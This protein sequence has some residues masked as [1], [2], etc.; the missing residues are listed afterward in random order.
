MNESKEEC[1]REFVDPLRR[2][3]LSPALLARIFH[4]AALVHFNAVAEHLSMREASRRLNVASSAVSRQITQLEDALGMALFARDG[5]RLA[6]SPAGEILFRHTRRLS[7]VLEAAVG[8]LEM[9]RGLKTG[10]VRVA[11]AESVGIAFLPRVIAEFGTRYPRLHIEVSVTSSTEVIR[12][13]V[14]D[15][16]EIGFGFV[17]APHRQIDVALR[18]DVRIGVAMRPDHPLSTISGPLTLTDCLRHPIAVATPEISIRK[19]IEPFLQQ[20]GQALPPLVE[21]DSIR[22]LVELAL[23]GRYL[24][25]MTPIGAQNEIATGA[26]I[27]RRLD[28]AGLPENRF[29]LMTRSSGTLNLAAAMFLEHARAHFEAIDLPGSV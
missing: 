8:E 24:S 26:L 10:T 1:A 7:C 3:A 16:A 9:L 29:G 23:S 27:I 12:R 5:R 11:T 19:V 28:Q 14:E 13:L 17:T 4:Q 21:V 6:L 18:R 2:S 20:S 22:M 15:R 25:I